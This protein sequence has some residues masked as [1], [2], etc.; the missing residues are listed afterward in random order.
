MMMDDWRVEWVRMSKDQGGLHRWPS[1]EIVKN[2]FSHSP[3]DKNSKIAEYLTAFECPLCSVY[4]G[5]GIHTE[6]DDS[7][8]RV[9]QRIPRSDDVAVA[10]VWSW[11]PLGRETR[12]LSLCGTP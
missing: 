8:S 2:T 12:D 6:E 1:I 7:L 3:P 11:N 9:G 10:V 4:I 5:H